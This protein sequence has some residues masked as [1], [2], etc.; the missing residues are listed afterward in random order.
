MSLYIQHR[1][2]RKPLGTYGSVDGFP[3]GVAR[4]SQLQTGDRG[5]S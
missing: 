3:L 2:I 5:K 4:Y 1:S